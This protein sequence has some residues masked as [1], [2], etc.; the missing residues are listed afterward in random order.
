MT[1]CTAARQS[2]GEW[3]V[4]AVLVGQIETVRQGCGDAANGSN[5]PVLPVF[6]DA[7]KVRN[8]GPS[9]HPG[10]NC[11][12]CLVRGM[13]NDLQSFAPVQPFASWTVSTTPPSKTITI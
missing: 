9:A 2:V 10:G 5:E 6:Y 13:I 4:W 3:P 8:S 11:G 7:A 12:E 1:G